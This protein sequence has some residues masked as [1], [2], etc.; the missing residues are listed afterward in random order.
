MKYICPFHL[1]IL[2]TQNDG[3]DNGGTRKWGWIVIF[4]FVTFYN[5]ETNNYIPITVFL[6]AQMFCLKTQI[7][8]D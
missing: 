6:K 4:S 3:D 2:G 5:K 7:N 8:Y 1:H